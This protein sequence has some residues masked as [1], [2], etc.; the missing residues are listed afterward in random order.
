MISDHQRRAVER[1]PAAAQFAH[2]RAGPEKSFHRNGAERHNHFWFD[3]VDL[4]HQIRPAGLHF[5]RSWCAIS[6]RTGRHVGT[7]FENVADVDLLAR[8]SAGGDDLV[9][10]LTRCADK[11]K[12]LGVFII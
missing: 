1:F 7:A 3:D 10:E 11:G 12:P 6:E 8:E 9:E 5:A 4:F 2:R